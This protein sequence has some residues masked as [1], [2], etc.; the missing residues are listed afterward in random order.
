LPP[1]AADEDDIWSL[2]TM[3]QRLVKTGAV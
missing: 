1:G 2:T 3:Q